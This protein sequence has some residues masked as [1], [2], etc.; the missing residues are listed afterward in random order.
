MCYTINTVH[1]VGL[2]VDALIICSM[3]AVPIVTMVTISQDLVIE[4]CLLYQ[5][6]TITHSELVQSRVVTT[7]GQK[8]NLGG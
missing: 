8:S 4:G 5:E 3:H 2:S 7:Y 1:P 6:V